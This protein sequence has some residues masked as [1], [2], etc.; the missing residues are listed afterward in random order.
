MRQWLKTL[1]E[2]AVVQQAESSASCQQATRRPGHEQSEQ[3]HATALLQHQSLAKEAVEVTIRQGPNRDAR[4]TIS[5]QRKVMASA[6]AGSDRR[7]HR[8]YS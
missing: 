1:L 7:S 4:D 3:R 6:D 8:S 5:A 2:T